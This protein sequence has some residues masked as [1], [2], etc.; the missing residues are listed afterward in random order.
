MK[1][2]LIFQRVRNHPLTAWNIINNYFVFLEDQSA[3]HLEE[4]IESPGRE[5][6]SAKDSNQSYMIVRI[7]IDASISL[8]RVRIRSG[9]VDT[10]T[11]SNCSVSVWDQ[12]LLI[13]SNDTLYYINLSE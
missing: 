7:A 2:Q 6:T 13:A 10:P 11:L 12:N 5:Q 8:W 1:R 4:R 3:V 9:G